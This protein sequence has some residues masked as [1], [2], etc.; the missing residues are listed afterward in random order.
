MSISVCNDCKVPKLLTHDKLVR[1]LKQIDVGISDLERT[2]FEFD[3]FKYR[4]E[5]EELPN[6]DACHVG[7]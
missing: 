4:F 1:Q 3:D 7:R 6:E 5:L 2:E